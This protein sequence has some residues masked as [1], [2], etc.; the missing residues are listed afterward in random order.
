MLNNSIFC[1]IFCLSISS[2]SVADVKVKIKD[3]VSLLAV[4]GVEFKAGRYFENKNEIFLKNG[5][6]KLLIQYTAE[7]KTSS[8]D[9]ELESTNP[10][11]ILFTEADVEL[12]L[13]V[14]RIR[15]M[16]ELGRLESKGEWRFHN[17]SGQPIAFKYDVLKKEGFQL[18]RDYGREL[19][20]YNRTQS[21]AAINLSNSKFNSGSYQF[22]SV[23]D[24][25]SAV[26]INNMPE[27]MLR[28]WY[29]QADSASRERFKIWIK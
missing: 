17:V 19:E 27:E 9:Y 18:S 29:N 12:I 3:G 1:L 6:N 28:Y 15:N 24:K 2:V 11:V 20:T 13:G 7:I 16:S 26:G 22:E 23:P 10:H 8:S 21:I 4:N 14:P 5:S 25:A